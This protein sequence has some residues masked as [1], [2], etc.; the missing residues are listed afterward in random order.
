MGGPCAAAQIGPSELRRQLLQRRQ[1]QIGPD[2]RARSAA[3]V[4]IGQ[5]SGHALPAGRSMQAP[6]TRYWYLAQPTML[7]SEWATV[8]RAACDLSYNGERSQ[9][10]CKP[11]PLKIF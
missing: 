10:K 4:E 7:F 9:A 11:I 2:F 8:L 1:R 6:H 5:R 3:S